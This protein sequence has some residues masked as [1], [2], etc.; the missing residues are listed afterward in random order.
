VRGDAFVNVCEQI[1]VTQLAHPCAF[2]ISFD[3]SH[4]SLVLL[5]VFL[6]FGGQV[7]RSAFCDPRL[8]HIANDHLGS[9]I[10][11]EFSWSCLAGTDFRAKDLITGL[12]NLFHFP[13]D[14]FLGNA[15]V[16]YLSAYIGL[17][18][19]QTNAHA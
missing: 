10:F 19:E 17:D 16:S 7:V 2:E 15:S 12:V 1:E 18:Q 13:E 6:D 5:D 11:R 4:H 9:D 14:T 3:D 8:T